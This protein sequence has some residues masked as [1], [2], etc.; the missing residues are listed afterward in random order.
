MLPA[1]HAYL[2]ETAL[3]GAGHAGLQARRAMVQAGCVDEDLIRVPFT[4]WR[5]QSPGLSHT[6]RP[7]R[8]RGELGAPSALAR[9]ERLI[10]E[11][12]AQWRRAPDR[13]AHHVGRACHLLGD[14]AVPARTR[15]VWHPL[16]D[17]YERWVDDHLEEL[18][19]E[20]AAPTVAAPSIAAVVD[21][22]ARLAAVHA[23]DTT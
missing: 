14:V 13:A 11:A 12:C 17:P 23:A 18:A 10:D 22:L 19:T 9:I 3:D 20:P 7:G 5:V 4:R 1:T 21:R 15:G 2:I 16:G 8:A 6:Y